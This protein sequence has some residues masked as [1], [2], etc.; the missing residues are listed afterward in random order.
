MTLQSDSRRSRSSS[1]ARPLRSD[2]HHRR[3]RH[4]RKQY[5]WGHSDHRHRHCRFDLADLSL[6]WSFWLLVVGWFWLM[7]VGWSGCGCEIWDGYEILV[8][9]V[10]FF[11]VG[12]DIGCSV[13]LSFFFFFLF[14]VA[15]IGGWWLI[16]GGGQWLWTMVVDLRCG[17]LLLLLMIMGDEIIY[18]FNV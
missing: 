18:Y 3:R 13:C 6:C 15:D 16:C 12:A 9:G 17:L 2:H 4:R 7:V 1:W 11:C 14:A 8:N 10:F 5:G